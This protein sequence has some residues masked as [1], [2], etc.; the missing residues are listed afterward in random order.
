MEFPDARLKLPEPRAAERDKAAQETDAGCEIR[1]VPAVPAGR[2]A[3]GCDREC[4]ERRAL[5][6]RRRR[7]ASLL[8]AE[9][10]GP[11]ARE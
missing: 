9:I 5:Q 10:H 2:F 8:E 3:A 1:I 4:E 7:R 11:P 6:Q